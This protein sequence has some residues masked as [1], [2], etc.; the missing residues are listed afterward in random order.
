LTG[1][2]DDAQTWD[3]SKQKGDC[4]FVADPKGFNGAIVALVNDAGSYK[5]ESVLDVTMKYSPLYI[6]MPED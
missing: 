6:L 5:V 2:L 4:S 1:S 3:I